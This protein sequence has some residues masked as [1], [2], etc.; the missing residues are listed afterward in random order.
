MLGSRVER[1][2][3]VMNVIMKISEPFDIQAYTFKSEGIHLSSFS[4]GF[5][6]T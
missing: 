1:L 5:K 4:K 6:I 3:W 2:F